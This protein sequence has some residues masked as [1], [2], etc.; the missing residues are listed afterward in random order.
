MAITQSGVHQ[1]GS[2]GPKP[3]RPR[4]T[5]MRVSPDGG[6][7]ITHAYTWQADL[8]ANDAK[9]DSDTWV[10]LATS[11][12]FAGHRA[13][14][15]EL[16]AK[17]F[18]EILAN[19]KATK[20]RRVPWD[21]EHASE[22]DPTEGSLPVTGAP[23]PAWVVDMEIRGG[24]LWGLVEWGKQLRQQVRD[25]EYRFLSPAIVFNSVDRVSG[26]PIGARLSSVAATNKPFLDGMQPLAATEANSATAPVVALAG[27]Y[28]H[29]THEY[30]P[31]LRACMGMDDMA[32]ATE[33]SEQFTR[34]CDW[35]DAGSGEAFQGVDVPGYVARFRQAL[36][37]PMGTTWEDM[38]DTVEAMIDAAIEEHEERMHATT[39]TTAAGSGAPTIPAQPEPPGATTMTEQDKELALKLS[40]VTTQNSELALT[41]KDV[42]TKLETANKSITELTAWKA[43]RENGD[44]VAMVDA[45]FDTYKDSKKLTDADKEAMLDVAKNAP[46][47]FAKLYPAVKMSER[48][49]M[50]TLSTAPGPRQNAPILPVHAGGDESIPDMTLRLMKEEKLSY[51]AALNKAY[52]LRQSVSA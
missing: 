37:V 7:D 40:Q 19:F 49:L 16:N 33:C 32:T 17:V 28:V 4:R 24:N 51:N 2:M 9:G 21:Y 31:V 25:G 26:K 18:R 44:V 41:L 47:S 39:M 35:Y 14:P 46:K 43:E 11:G 52:R 1:P 30:M 45:A 3:K 36:N 23:A 12:T 5:R 27:R 34:I 38:V 48:H 15:F 13:G 6:I 50:R 42:T 29:A 10:Q 8:S 22:Q 20:N